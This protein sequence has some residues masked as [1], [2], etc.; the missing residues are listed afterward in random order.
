MAKN[1]SLLFLGIGAVALVAMMGKAKAAPPTAPSP[2]PDDGEGDEPKPQGGEMRGGTVDV[3]APPAPTLPASTES[4][5]PTRPMPLT[6]KPARPAAKPRPAPAPP[7]VSDVD[8]VVEHVD[9]SLRGGDVSVVAPRPAAKPAQKKPAPRPP[10]ATRPTA[11]TKNGETV[12]IAPG[13]DQ[14]KA[15]SLAKGVAANIAAKKYDFNRPGLRAFQIAAG[16]SP[17]SIYGPLSKSALTYYGAKAPPAL[18]K[19]GAG[20]AT[21]YTP[22]A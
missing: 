1:S 13:Y 4:S 21:T 11:A 17:D 20:Q 16:I 19:A 22:P 15:R 14:A 10:S 3:F 18:A 12:Y 5:E 8:E 6:G 9:G 2:S 7:V